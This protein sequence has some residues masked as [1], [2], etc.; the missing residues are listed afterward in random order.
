MMQ[1]FTWTLDT[2]GC[3]VDLEFD[4]SLPIGRNNVFLGFEAIGLEHQGAGAATG[5]ALYDI[6]LAENQ[7]RMDTLTLV[8]QAV[9]L[10]ATILANQQAVKDLQTKYFASATYSPAVGANPRVLN[11]DTTKAL[12]TAISA[13]QVA[14]LKTLVA[15]KFTQ[16]QVVIV[17]SVVATGV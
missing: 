2:C 13:V 9:G 11:V 14:T 12:T 17:T 16:G 3:I 5:K 8:E 1:P 6:I 10:D 7:A 4:D 15:A